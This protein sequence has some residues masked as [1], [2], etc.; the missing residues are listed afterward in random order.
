MANINSFKLTPE[1]GDLD[2]QFPGGVISGR[3]KSD[4]SVALVATQAVKIANTS[5]GAPE[6][7]AVAGNGETA[8]GFVV[9]N[10]KD[11]SDAAGDRLEVA[12]LGAV[13]WMT[14]GGAI[15]RGFP[16]EYVVSSKKV[17]ASAGVNPVVGFALDKAAAD[18][19]IIRVMIQPSLASDVGD[20]RTAKV[21]ATLAEINAGKTLIS[22]PGAGYKIRVVDFINRISG[23]FT[24]TTSVDLQ[25]GAAT[26]VAVSAVA[27]LTNGT[28]QVPGSANVTLGAGFGADLTDN[29]P[30]NVANVGT[31]AAGGTSITYTITY[32][33]VPA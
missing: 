16:V 13:M 2:L 25:D 31:A 8:F 4:E 18:G 14:A 27:G 29:S 17:I 33:I 5:G 10:L 32:A 11:Q 30:L 28:V 7:T 6:F 21:T 22:A 24:T 3:V 15:G 26:K 1:A 12:S 19:D 20:L 23:T 9:R